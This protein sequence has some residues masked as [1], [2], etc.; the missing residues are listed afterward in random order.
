MKLKLKYS[1]G[2]ILN[3]ICFET[4]PQLCAVVNVA[5]I[6][7]HVQHDIHSHLIRCLDEPT[8][9]TLHQMLVPAHRAQV[10]I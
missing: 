5:R 1:S 8:A 6:Y 3:V 2:P 9:C 7:T 4:L 10:L